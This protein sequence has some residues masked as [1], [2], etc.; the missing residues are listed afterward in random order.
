MSWAS[1][2]RLM[3]VQCTSCARGV[4]MILFINTFSDS[5]AIIAI[6]WKAFKNDIETDKKWGFLVSLL[7]VFMY[8]SLKC[9]TSAISLVETACMFLIFL[10]TSMQISMECE[11]K[12]SEAKFEFILT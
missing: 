2:E 1:S 4:I 3:Y 9:K 6:Y 10:I 7:S 5:D 12:E 8:L 11:T